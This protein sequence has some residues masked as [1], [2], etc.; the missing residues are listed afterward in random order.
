MTPEEQRLEELREMVAE[1][2]EVEPDELT[3]TGDFVEDYE[4]DSLRAIEILARIDKAYK[5][6]IPQAELPE[7]RNLKAVHAAL[8]RHSGR[9]G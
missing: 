6:Q 5:V 1:V 2:L 4:A 7:L 8:L 9:R 3:D